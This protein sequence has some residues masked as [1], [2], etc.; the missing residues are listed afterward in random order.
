MALL[1]A[2]RGA[3]AGRGDSELASREPLNRGEAPHCDLLSLSDT[4]GNTDH[5]QR[6]DSVL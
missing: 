6:V 3:P 2:L 4:R 1:P 5:P